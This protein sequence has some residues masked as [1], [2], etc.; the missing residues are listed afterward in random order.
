[1]A[2]VDPVLASGLVYGLVSAAAYQRLVVLL[3]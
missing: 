2:N 3:V 1:M